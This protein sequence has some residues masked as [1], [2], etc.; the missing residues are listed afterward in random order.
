[1]LI[2]IEFK[3]QVKKKDNMRGLQIIFS[4]FR[5]KFDKFNNTVGRMSDTFYQMKLKSFRDHIWQENVSV[6]L[7]V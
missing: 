7:Y 1:M 4:L 3:K 6:L 5:N 2:F